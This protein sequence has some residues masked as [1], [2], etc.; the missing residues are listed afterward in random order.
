MASDHE[1]KR[2]KWREL[3]VS[4]RD[5]GAVKNADQK[6]DPQKNKTTLPVQRSLF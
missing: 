3:L 2:T 1:A 5:T 4:S 6:S